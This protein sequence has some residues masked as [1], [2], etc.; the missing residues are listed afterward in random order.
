MKEIYGDGC[1]ASPE[2]K[3]RIEAALAATKAWL[4]VSPEIDW[5]GRLYQ[6]ANRYAYLH[7]LREIGSVQAFLVNVYF[8][9]DSRTRTTKLEWDKAIQSVHQELGVVCEVPY[10]ACVFLTGE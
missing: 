8:V 6:S 5:T 7:F 4:G 3:Q 9:D 1:G 10:S 2:T